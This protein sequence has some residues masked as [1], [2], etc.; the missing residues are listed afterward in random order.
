MD[1]EIIKKFSPHDAIEY[2]KKGLVEEWVH[3]FLNTTGQ[4]IELSD[5][6]KKQKRYWTGPV[7][8]NLN[9]LKRCCGPEKN[10][11]FHEPVVNWE[12][13]INEMCSAIRTGW[14]VP[15]LIVEY[16]RNELSIRDGSHRYEAL[17]REKIKKYW[18][19]IWYNTIEDFLQ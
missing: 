19:I 12:K 14:I 10:M 2:S 1:T 4:N 15:P 9:K 3:N 7:E 11:E 17:I 5:G 8:I 16:R 13:R 6:L 18:V